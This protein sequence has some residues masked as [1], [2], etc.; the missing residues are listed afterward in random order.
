MV[1]DLPVDNPFSS[2]VRIMFW[3]VIVVV[4][5]AVVKLSLSV[6]IYIVVERI[7]EGLAAMQND[8][9]MTREYVKRALD[10][11]QD[12]EQTLG[13]VRETTVSNQAAMT[14]RTKEIKEAIREVPDKVVEKIVESGSAIDGTIAAIPYA[15]PAEGGPSQAVKKKRE[16]K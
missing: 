6:W 9:A 13:I 12:A 11:K 15:T 2:P 1:S 14:E 3:F 7:N 10:R 16:D 8:N 5:I 4:C